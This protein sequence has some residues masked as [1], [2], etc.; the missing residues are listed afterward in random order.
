MAEL[1][2]R[3]VITDHNFTDLKNEREI[4]EGAGG[5]L[6]AYQCRTEGDVIRHAADADGLIVQWAPITESVIGALQRCK[7]IVRYGIGV[8]NVNLEAAKRRGIT[9]CNVPDYC[10]DE[11]AD[12]TMAMA[13]TLLRQLPQTDRALHEGRWLAPPPTRVPAPSAL[14]FATVGLG[15][16][17]RAVLD[18]ARSFHFQ[19]AACDPYLSAAQSAETDIAVLGWDE[20]LRSADVL[21]LHIPLNEETQHIVNRKTI[22]R[23]KPSAILINTARGGLVD[24]VALAEA[25][26]GSSLAGA[27]LDVFETEPLAPHHPLLACRNAILTPHIAWYSEQSMKVLQRMAAEEVVRA[28]DG[29]EVRN[30]VT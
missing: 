16:T 12:H 24:T 28:L 13:L 8:D 2:P 7:V 26:Q 3:V 18:R 19:L 25:L 17:A 6:V 15:R 27:G 11:V 5:T 1:R 9:V 23:M 30:R 4:V 21:S 14:V 20:L 22:A 29:K 10:I